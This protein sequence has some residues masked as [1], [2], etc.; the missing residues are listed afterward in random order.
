[1]NSI[2]VLQFVRKLKMEIDNGSDCRFVFFLGAG[3]SVSSGIPDAATLVI[4][5]LKLLKHLQTGNVNDFDS[6]VKSRFPDFNEEK[7]ASF[8]G[9]IIE[10]LYPSSKA[11]Q[12]EVERIVEKSLP[13]FGYAIL[14]QLITHPIYGKYFNTIITTNFDDLAAD[15]IYLFTNKKPLVI[16]HESLI[17]FVRISSFQPVIIKLHGD[18]RFAPK[19]IES[20]TKSLDKN[21]EK[22]LNNLFS[23]RGIIFVGYGGND[24][25]IGNLLSSLS[26]NSLPC[27]IYWVGNRL[28]K[29]VIGEWLQ[30]RNATWVKHQDFDELM[31][32]TWYYFN[33][34]HP[35]L[36]K[37]S[38]ILE[39]YIKTFNLIKSQVENNIDHTQKIS[40]K[41]IWEEALN[42]FENDWHYEVERRGDKSE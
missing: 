8:Y 37:F 24:K 4:Y 17:N 2:D 16:Y 5:W 42:K 25:S 41:N 30:S 38:R 14:A 19:N 35:D 10:E 31:L 29:S 32:I 9:R 6:W 39:V 40:I 7:A 26:K 11:R 18:V 1:M 3:C 28:P 27:G 34:K 12:E 36:N 33:L 22:T 15:A 21:V 20:E 23:E 13:S